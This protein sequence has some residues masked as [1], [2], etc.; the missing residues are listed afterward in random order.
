[1]LPYSDYRVG[2]AEV[3]YC[4]GRGNAVQGRMVPVAYTIASR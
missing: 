3:N 4:T 1:M 2:R